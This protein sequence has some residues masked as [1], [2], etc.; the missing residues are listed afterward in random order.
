[1][2][3]PGH[4]QRIISFIVALSFFMEA[5][6]STVIN[7]AIPSIARSLM[8]NP[9]QLKLALI[10]YLLSL[11]VFIP[12][13]GR[14]SDKFGA[15]RV[16]ITAL[17]TFTLSSLACGFASNLPALIVARIFQGF[18]GALGLPVGRLILI[19][20]FGRE[21]LITIMNTVVMVGALGMMLGP[22]IGGV[23][24]HFFS[25]QWIFWINIPVGMIT[26]LLAN[27]YLPQ[28]KPI[29]VPPLDRPG[30]ILFGGGLAGF[31]LGLSAL[32]ET[33][34]PLNTSLLII[35]VS[36]LLL[37]S[38]ALHS[39][40]KPNPV[41]KTDLLRFRTFRVSVAG[42]L[43]TRL[44]FGG[45]PFLVPLF[46]QLALGFPANV[47]GFLLA[48]VALGVILGKPFTLHFLRGLGYRRFLIMNTLIAGLFIMSFSAISQHT[49]VYAIGALTFLYGFILTLQYGAV[50]SLAYADLSP[51]DFSAA[52]SIMST[53]QQI[54]QSF[55]VAIGALLI[56]LFVAM[57]S[58]AGLLSTKVFHSTF[59]ALGLLTM[60]S[61]SIFVPL[62]KDDGQQMLFVD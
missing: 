37:I 12:I 17:V 15:K 58:S 1:M 10:S 22:M 4:P 27:H 38:Y 7:T 35:A 19:R 47:A 51:D 3:H 21:H 53:L 31:T 20:A 28:T 14:L 9:I 18:G 40:K 13:S 62:K 11:A 56:H 2:K 57:D 24:T 33:I 32:S 36:I 23:I 55:G 50:N 48:P 26:I 5:L 52:N 6:D 39:H 41:V 44:G 42:N 30:F 16:F 59:I 8:V 29:P 45:M 34:I 54:A 61:G 49:P 46:L 60:L 25:W 43:V